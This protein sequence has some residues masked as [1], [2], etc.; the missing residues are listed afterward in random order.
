MEVIQETFRHSLIQRTYS[1]DQKFPKHKE[2]HQEIMWNQIKQPNKFKFGQ[3]K[4]SKMNFR[5]SKR[6][7][8][9]KKHFQL[10]EPNNR[11]KSSN[12]KR[13]LFILINTV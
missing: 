10:T 7:T 11:L 4:I 2:G 13:K 1:S 3:V 5:E 12:N 8:K 6:S 9:E